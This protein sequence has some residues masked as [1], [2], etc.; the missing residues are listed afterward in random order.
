MPD[1]DRVGATPLRVWYTIGDT[2]VELQAKL[3]TCRICGT[4]TDHTADCEC[5]GCSNTYCPCHT[6]CP[7]HSYASS[8]HGGSDAGA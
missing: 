5:D 4:I 8:T 3:D 1:T 7:R 2:V 6:F